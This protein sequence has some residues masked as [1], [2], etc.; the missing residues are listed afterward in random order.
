M[1]LRGSLSP[2]ANAPGGLPPGTPWRTL[3]HTHVYMRRMT[4]CAYVQTLRRVLSQMGTGRWLLSPPCVRPL[5]PSCRAKSC[6]S[7]TCDC[8]LRPCPV[9]GW[10]CAPGCAR[11]LAV[12]QAGSA[13]PLCKRLVCNAC[14]IQGIH[15]PLSLLG[16]PWSLLAT[17]LASQPSR[18][19][20]GIGRSWIFLMIFLCP[21][22]WRCRLRS[23]FALPVRPPVGGHILSLPLY[24][25][26]RRTSTV[27]E[28]VL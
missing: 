27:Q 28:P 16:L 15:L 8:T 5:P 25:A 4:P 26:C 12:P 24:R 18:S 3:P 19:M 1:P 13:A 11:R 14:C 23:P 20:S 2:L 7:T 21:A 22:P 10:V 6:P 9:S 17:P